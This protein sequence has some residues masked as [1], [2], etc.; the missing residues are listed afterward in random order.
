MIILGLGCAFE[1]DPAAALIVDGR[2]IAAAEE[3][4]FTRD[5]HAVDQLPIHAGRFVLE[6][7]GVTPGE[8]DAVAFPWCADAYRAGRWAHARRSLRSKPSHAYKAFAKT[9]SRRRRTL[10]KALRTMRALDVPDATELVCVEHH[11]AHASSAYHVSGFENAAILSI[12]GKGEFTA[13]LVAEGRGGAIHK[14]AEIV[15][16]DSLGLF[17]A[18]VT[19]YLGFQHHDGEYKVMGMSAYGDASRAPIEPLIQLGSG[20]YRINDDLVWVRKQRRWRGHRYSQALVDLWGPPREGEGLAEPYIH[21]AAAAQVALEDAVLALIDHHLPDLLRRN[22]GRLCLAG[23]CALNVR[24]N[25][26]ILDH[27]LVQELYVPPSPGDAGTAV[28][29]ATW[30]AHE[31]G[32]KIVPMLHAYHGPSYGEPEIRAVLERF[33]IPAEWLG[34]DGA[35]ERAA[36]LLAGGEILAWFQ[37][38]MEFGPR[39]LGNRSI[40]GN[41]SIP[42][43]SDEINR[44]IKFRETWRPFCPSI[45]ADEAPAILGSEHASHFMNLSFRV[46]DEWRTRAPEIVHV[47]GSCRPQTVRREFNPKFHALLEEFRRRT[48]LPV[49]I[50]TSLNRRSEPMVCSPED[51]LA[52]FYGCGLEHLMLG[53]FY[54]TKRAA[55]KPGRLS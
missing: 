19:D 33:R 9:A 46:S 18:T 21:I 36:E 2:V 42:G 14:I 27:P 15:E 48:G 44:R 1:H 41:P 55:A 17:Y 4:R 30:V 43:T 13:T 10:G 24:M 52:M 50:N 45:L 51:A 31:R 5:K 7:A 54:V 38:R 34:A 22:G 39:A 32:D 11:M 25:R 28:G 3:E 20:A 16:P 40:L 49:L 47:D 23:G 29:A 35:V 12:D 26:R 53:D 6:Q 37:G 8:L